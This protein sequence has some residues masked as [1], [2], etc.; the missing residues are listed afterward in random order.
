MHSLSQ[1]SNQSELSVKVRLYYKRR[2]PLCSFAYLD[3]QRCTCELNYL[4][5]L[6]LEFIFTLCLVS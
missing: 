5:N 3:H 6:S 2:D 4:K 1:I